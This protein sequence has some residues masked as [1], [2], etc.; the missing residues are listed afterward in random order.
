MTMEPL[1]PGITMVAEA[2]TRLKNNRIM[3]LGVT[4]KLK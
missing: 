4:A 1:T 3:V 2:M